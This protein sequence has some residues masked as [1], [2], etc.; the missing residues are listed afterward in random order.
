MKA[1]TS[2]AIILIT[3]TLMA[4]ISSAQNGF[5]ESLTSHDNFIV[6]NNWGPERWGCAFTRTQ[7]HQTGDGTQITIGKDS[8]L[9]PFSCGELIYKEDKLG[10]GVYSIDM[11]ASNVLGQVTS[12]FLIS[13]GVTEIDIELTGLNTR[14]GW[15]NVWHD[16]KQNPVSIKLPFD[17]SQGWHSYSFNWNPRYIAWSVDGNVVLNRSD[18]ATTPPDQTDYKLAINSWTQVQPELNVDWAGKFTY[19]TDGSIPTA[20]FRN[21]KYEPHGYSTEQSTPDSSTSSSS[22]T[23][24]TTGS[25]DNTPNGNE[26]YN[27]AHPANSDNNPG[28]KNGG[29]SPNSQPTGNPTGSSAESTKSPTTAFALAGTAMTAVA[30]AFMVLC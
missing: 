3:T 20:R 5:Q 10:Y 15:M 12:F 14:L 11:I 30:L 27:N 24:D 29:Q 17:A 26:S 16:Q 23:T 2:V 25:N 8:T 9:K 7:V 1:I 4:D 13:N 22:N 21:M 19:P 6:A 18:I 28:S